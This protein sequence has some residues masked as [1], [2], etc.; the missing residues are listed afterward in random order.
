MGVLDPIRRKS[1]LLPARD[2][3]DGSPLA[4]GRRPTIYR[5]LAPCPVRTTPWFLHPH[6]PTKPDSLS[7]DAASVKDEGTATHDESQDTAT[8]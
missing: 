2:F 1:P 3:Q 8:Q 7:L 4:D 6:P 5:L